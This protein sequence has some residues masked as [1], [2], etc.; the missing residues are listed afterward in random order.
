MQCDD[1]VKWFWDFDNA[2]IG[3]LLRQHDFGHEADELD[4]LLDSIAMTN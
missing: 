4:R 3:Y 1:E 2:P